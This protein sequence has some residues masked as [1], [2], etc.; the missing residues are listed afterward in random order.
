MFR[1]LKSKKQNR[2]RKSKNVDTPTQNRP[3]LEELKKECPDIYLQLL[4]MEYEDFLQKSREYFID[5]DLNKYDEDS[6]F[7]PHEACYFG[8]SIGHENKYVDI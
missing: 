1:F 4:I 2:G 3:S 6:I 5:N 8:S 7:F